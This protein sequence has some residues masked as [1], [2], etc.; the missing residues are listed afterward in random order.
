MP[1]ILKIVVINPRPK[2]K[3]KEKEKENKIMEFFSKP[4]EALGIITRVIFVKFRK[5]EKNCNQLSC[6]QILNSVFLETT[7]KISKNKKWHVSKAL[8]SSLVR[9]ISEEFR[10]VE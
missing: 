4:W 1:N 3:R 5:T 9:G 10:K 8:G 7:L 2:M 6:A